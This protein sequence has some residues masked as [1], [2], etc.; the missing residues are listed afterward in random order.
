MS[1]SKRIKILIADDERPARKF[2]RSLLDE[3]SDV[4]VIAEVENGAEAIDA[5]R[6]LSPDLALLDLEMPVKS[7]LDA[8]RALSKEE[9]PLVAFVTA[10]DGHAVQA[11]EVNAVDYLLKPVDAERLRETIDRAKER[12]KDESWRASVSE[13]L[14]SV[15][16]DYDQVRREGFIE[17]IP[18]KDGEDII[19]IPIADVSSVSA[20]GELLRIVTVENSRHIINHRLK[21][22]EL[23]LDPSR[24]VRLSRSAIVAI[25]DVDRVTPLPGGTFAVVMKNGLEF[26]SSRLQSRLLREKLLRL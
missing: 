10:F 20:D 17:R 14:A 12:L 1:E 23:R 3:M 6:E 22:L 2:L 9:M 8:V 25:D 15:A 11:F 13:N 18:V 16:D 24:F 26:Q 5:I 21:D 4:D 7:G 19:L